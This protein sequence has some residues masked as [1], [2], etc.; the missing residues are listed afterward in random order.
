MYFQAWEESSGKKLN[1]Q[2]QHNHFM[3]KQIL[4]GAILLCIAP[5]CFSQL[6]WQNVDSLYQP[7][8][9]SV[10]VY[11]TESNI[12]G[13]ANIA[14]YVEVDLKDKNL[15]FKSDTS[16]NR[17]LTPTQFFEKNKQ[18]LLVVN[19]S[20]FSFAT[21]QNLNIVMNNKRQLS[22]NVHSIAM[23]GKDTLKYA[24]V[25][26]SAIGISKNRKADIAWIYS[27]S[28]KRFPYASQTKIKAGIDS[29]IQLSLSGARK[30]GSFKKWK[31][32]TAVG[33]GPVLLQDGAIAIS[34][35]EEMKFGGKAIDDK[36]PRTGMGFTQEGKLII[37]AVQGRFPLIAEGASLIQEAQI[38]K[39]LGCIEAINLDGG[40]S[41]CLLINGKETI[42][43]S[44]KEGQRPIPAVFIV[45]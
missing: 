26:G 16:N 27:D 24:H 29:T 7:L 3:I 45:Q 6:I 32:Q 35:N 2:L 20:F 39:D 30:M 42:K 11:K 33:G 28:S 37:L 40:G 4:L 43:P 5:F 38:F 21:H 10:H 14:Y 17:R 13:K 36:H 34:N 9:K 12:D 31:I 1:Q 41:S 25:F 23:K 8:P 15:N 22:Y 19:T 18:A 44:D